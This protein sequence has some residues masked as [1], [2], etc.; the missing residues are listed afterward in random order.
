MMDFTMIGDGVNLASRLESA[1][2]Q[3]AANILISENTYKKLRG[4]YRIRE[5]DRV[6]VKGKSEP[7]G[8]YE[9][10]D[11][12]NDDTFPNLMEG[13]NHFKNGLTQYRR[14]NWAR[15]I[16]AFKEALDLNRQDRLSRIYIER[17]HHLKENP[18]GDDWNGV[19]IMTSK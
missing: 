6:V 19:W 4:T 3:Y 2:K 17:C 8:I 18:P 10:L 13:V 14:G 12:H 7:I 9:V 11:F 1:C 5:I 15:A 16:D